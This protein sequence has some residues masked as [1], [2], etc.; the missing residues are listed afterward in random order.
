MNAWVKKNPLSQKTVGATP[1]FIQDPKKS[2]RRRRSV[3]HEPSGIRLG[4][5][6]ELQR[7]GT[8]VCEVGAEDGDEFN[9][10]STQDSA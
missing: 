4:Y 9:K 3:T 1:F 5:A 8:C 7:R 10:I 2:N 6:A